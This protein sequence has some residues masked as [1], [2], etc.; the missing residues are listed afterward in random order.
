MVGKKT[1]LKSGNTTT[2]A[3]NTSTSN[4]FPESAEW[5]S[6][7]TAKDKLT[8]FNMQNIVSYFIERKAKG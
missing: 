2:S 8:D 3:V 4:D 7:T 1:S 6:L 5:S